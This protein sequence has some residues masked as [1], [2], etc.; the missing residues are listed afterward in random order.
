MDEVKE[1]LEVIQQE[2]RTGLSCPTKNPRD[3][4]T[5]RAWLIWARRQPSLPKERKPIGHVRRDPDWDNVA[6]YHI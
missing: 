6:G 4:K 1:L 2:V 5:M 3:V